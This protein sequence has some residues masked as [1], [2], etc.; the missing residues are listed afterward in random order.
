MS[1]LAEYLNLD[2]YDSA[3]SSRWPILRYLLRLD[4]PSL[5]G[6]GDDSPN[7]PTTTTT[8][9]TGE[10]NSAQEE[11]YFTPRPSSPVEEQAGSDWIALENTK[12]DASIRLISA[13]PE[14]KAY[15]QIITNTPLP[16]PSPPA[17]PCRDR[18]PGSGSHGSKS[19]PQPQR[20]QSEGRDGWVDIRS[21]T[22]RLAG[23]SSNRRRT[24]SQVT[25]SPEARQTR[26]NDELANEIL[27]MSLEEIS[28]M[29]HRSIR[30]VAQRQADES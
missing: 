22:S 15:F 26:R 10:E 21:S 14:Q 20:S 13:N 6:S 19:R 16:S 25:E 5:Q 24:Q 27:D 18:S 9:T 23:P 1:R 12:T 29:M 30:A 3:S 28:D 2:A 17:S 7:P 4:V 11:H 8:E